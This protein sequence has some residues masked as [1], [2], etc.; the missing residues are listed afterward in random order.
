MVQVC[1]CEFRARSVVEGRAG[2]DGT[3][4]RDKTASARAKGWEHVTVSQLASQRRH[5]RGGIEVAGEVD[6]DGDDRACD[7][8]GDGGK[9]GTPRDDASG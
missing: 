9:T 7:G 2:D 5:L 3:T 4:P 8:V 6:L 1:E